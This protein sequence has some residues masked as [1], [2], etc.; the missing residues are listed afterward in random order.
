MAED[1]KSFMNSQSSID[2]S[3]VI[4]YVNFNQSGSCISVG[5]NK[6]VTIFNSEPFGKYY[7]S[8]DSPSQHDLENE[9]N[10]NTDDAKCN[11]GIVEMVYNTALL[12]CV[13]LGEQ[14]NLS[15]RKLR[16]VNTRK[17]KTIVEFSFHSAILSI[18][19]NKSRL[20]ILLKS[21]IYIYD[22]T[23]MKLLHLIETS[24]LF[25]GIIDISQVIDDKEFPQILC[26]SSPQKVI[27]SEMNSHLTTNNLS[28]LNKVGTGYH[29][30]N[31]KLK[32][33]SGEDSN[34]F[35]IQGP[36]NPTANSHGDIVIF[37]L[38]TLQPTHVIN[39][40]KAAIS[41]FKLNEKG[42][43]LATSSVKGTIVRVF[44]ISRGIKK[45]QFRRGT[46]NTK[47]YCL[48]FDKTDQFLLCCSSNLT[49]HIFKMNE[50]TS[51]EY[52][53]SDADNLNKKNSN[54]QDVDAEPIVD[55]S[56]LTM[57]RIIRKSSQNAMKK[58]GNALNLKMTGL[59]PN[60]H[61][62]SL[63]IP[64]SKSNNAANM[65][66]SFNDDDNDSIR[67]GTSM[68][69]NAEG[70]GNNFSINNSKDLE[71]K[72]TF[73][74]FI[75]INIDE[76]PEMTNKA[77]NLP[78]ME[79]PGSINP[80]NESAKYDTKLLRVLPIYVVT[81]Q[82]HFYK[83]FLDPVNGGDCILIQDYQMVF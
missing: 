64:S 75:D 23:T 8:M 83:Y 28:L 56:R 49:V 39:A 4:N 16:L 22:I 43:L 65:S 72:A 62:A 47:I 14:V 76:Y 27:S 18:K 44:D 51:Q 79:H 7:T 60:R 2:N 15:P 1:N 21:Q 48:Q 81:S 53:E 55:N 45:Y 78:D 10:S 25:E 36:N 6:G 46:Y 63:K 58:I 69:S 41:T 54:E 66:S 50:E 52:M 11:F 19:M 20:V 12:A 77:V 59:E 17:R 5:T 80:E 26:Y 70:G 29:S 37:N 82:G 30:N 42:T 71:I 61:F 3:V 34:D 68:H 24:D 35:E 9:E 40:H 33:I 67:T 13:G 31:T 73:A 74:D 32:E 57:G 38:L